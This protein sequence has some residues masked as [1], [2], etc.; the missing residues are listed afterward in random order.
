MNPLGVITAGGMLTTAGAVRVVAA[1][2][3]APPKLSAALAQL[4]A[5]PTIGDRPTPA[6]QPVRGWGVLPGPVTRFVHAHVGVPDADLQILGS[7]RPQLAATKLT[8]AAT[9][10]V[11]PTLLTTLLTVTGARPPLLFPVAFTLIL[12]GALWVGPSND[13]RKN[14]ARARAEF[15]AAL[16][17]FLKLVAQ[18]RAAR[19]SPTEALEEA[20]RGWR[21]W[22]YRLIHTEVLRAELAGQQ[23][24]HALAA[25][26]QRLGVPELRS[27]ADIVA[28]A[29]DGAAVF[30]TLLAEARTLHHAELSAHRAEANAASERLIQPIGLLA[31]GFV[32]MIL[33]PPVLRL[34]TT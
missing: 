26:G 30:D 32:V 7:T 3:P 11:A 6:P 2:R 21:G 27:L 16:R 8:R 13:V 15:R 9:G 22:P 10:L 4:V 28:T 5:T 1:L 14:A 33:I 19:G 17:A 23:P 29:A 31:F 18:E 25:L 20:S 12:T 24:W 34:F